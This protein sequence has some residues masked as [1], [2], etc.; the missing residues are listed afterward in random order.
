VLAPLRTFG[1]PL[2]DQIQPIAYAALI[3]A[4]NAFFPK[5]RRYFI[6]TRSLDGLRAET[7]EALVASARRI[8]SPFSALSIHHFHGA[9]SRVAASATAFAPRRDHLM[10]EIVAGW[11]PESA[12]AEQQHVRWAQGA[13]R[14]LAPY[15]LPGGYI[16]LLDV[17]EQER[18]PPAFGPNYGRL[19]DLKRAYDP[20][21]VFRSTVGHI[22]P[23]V[24]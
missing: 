4:L 7:I 3:N 11:E 15:A 10:V 5:G 24:S 1:K 9:A 2:A 14:A 20:E 18:V 8:T 21:D 12:E 19:L 22:T 13:S 6:Q 17:G 23:T 16:S